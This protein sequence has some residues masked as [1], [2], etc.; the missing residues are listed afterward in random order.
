MS[1]VAAGFGGSTGARAAWARAVLRYLTPRA[2]LTAL[3]AE[4]ER[5]FLWVPVFLGF[6]IALY[7]RPRGASR[8][9]WRRWHHCGAAIV[10]SQVWR[11][12]SLAVMIDR[13]D[14]GRRHRLRPG[15]GPDRFRRRAGAGQAISLRRRARLR[16]T[17]R[18][19]GDARSAHHAAAGVVRRARTR[20]DAVSDTRPHH[21]GAGRPEAG[22][23]AAAARDARRLPASRRCRATTISHAAA[24]FMRLGGI[25]YTFMR[26][27]L[28]PDLG[29]PPAGLRFWAAIERLRQAIG[30]RITAALPGETG[31]DRQR[32]R[33]PAS[34]AASRQAT[35]DAYRDSGLF[36]ILSISGLHMVIMAGA[37]FWVVRLAP[38]AGA[39][40]RAALADQ[41]DRGRGGDRGGARLSADLRRLARDG[42]IVDHDLDDVLRGDPGPAGAAPAQCRAV[43]ARHPGGI[44]REPVRCRL[45]DVVRRGRGAG[46]RLRGDPRTRGS[47]RRRPAEP[48]HRRTACCSS[49]ASS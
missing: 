4:Q 41:E 46:V 6:G 15:E 38:G 5:W 47:G 49:A 36:H 19:A 26:P 22:R 27:A 23:S 25:G 17:G 12:G 13:S 1:E 30:Q 39:G 18:A 11:R 45:P 2:A 28:D 7:F 24:W 42:A 31:A 40:D 14:A 43:R 29:Q 48:R 33:S 44:P 16:R 34:A 21:G 8:R 10:I 32:P 35:N 20:E 3:E 9:C 37:V